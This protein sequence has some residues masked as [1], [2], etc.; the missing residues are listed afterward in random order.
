MTDKEP[1]VSEE[2]KNEEEDLL[3]S[4]LD[5]MDN[6][7]KLNLTNDEADGDD[8]FDPEMEKEFQKFMSDMSKG[9]QGG[10]GNQEEAL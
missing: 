3:D 2:N 5:D 1:Q 7:E 6:N 4:A 9:G 10:G 8:V